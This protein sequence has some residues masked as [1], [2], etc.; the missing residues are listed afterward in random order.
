MHVKAAIKYVSVHH[1]DGFMTGSVKDTELLFIITSC[2]SLL[3]TILHITV[4]LLM[5]LVVNCESKF[6]YFHTETFSFYINVIT[7]AML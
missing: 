1:S 4:S 3:K 6:L 5:K 2:S 7:S